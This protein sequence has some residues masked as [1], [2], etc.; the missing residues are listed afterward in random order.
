MAALLNM[1]CGAVREHTAKFSFEWFLAVHIT[2]PL[3]APLRK[4]I[5]MPRWAIALTIASAIAGQ[6]AG[7]RMERHRL[8][9]AAQGKSSSE[10]Q[11][12]QDG[13]D[14]WQPMADTFSPPGSLHFQGRQGQE[15]VNAPITSN[16][17]R[18]KAGISSGL[19][20]PLACGFLGMQTA[21]TA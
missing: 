9:T 2:I 1:P 13:P 16:A 19:Q 4:A 15:C 18:N 21:L 6:L 14:S 12:Q 17:C 3:V 20:M 7:S 10:Q 11:Q 5:L 8:T